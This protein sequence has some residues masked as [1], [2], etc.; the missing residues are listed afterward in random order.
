MVI[1]D[2]DDEA[3]YET[4]DWQDAM[5]G[6]LAPRG[7][8]A[9][10]LNQ[11]AAAMA[12]VYP[13]L[14]WCGDDHV[15]RTAGWDKAMLA[16]LEQLGGHGWVYPDTVRRRD[17]PEIWL[18]SSDVVR[19]LGWFFPPAMGHYYGDNA[20]GELGKRTGLIR[21]CPEAVVEHLH[22]SVT[23][24]AER[25]A[26]YAEAEDQHGAA[27]LAAFQEWRAGQMGNDVAVL[28]RQFSPDVAWV[29]SRV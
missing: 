12:A 20:V 8:L 24:G 5:H 23:P 18:S 7:T 19:A 21:C 22:Y 27:D 1:L 26:T 4:V 13:A 14:M 25:D 11:T 29:L 6:V 10:K 15:F 9:V 2:E 16:V 28:R 3:A 17:V